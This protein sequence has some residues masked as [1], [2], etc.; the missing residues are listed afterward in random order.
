MSSALDTDNTFHRW[1][2]PSFIHLFCVTYTFATCILGIP[3]LMVVICLLLHEGAFYKRRL[4]KWRRGKRRGHGGMLNADKE[5]AK[6]LRTSF[7]D[8]P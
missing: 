5:G 3:S 1:N 8:A 4:Q 6:M 7:M 2:I